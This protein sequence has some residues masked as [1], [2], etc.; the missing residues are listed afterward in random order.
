[1]GLHPDLARMIAASNEENPL[2]IKDMSPDQARALLRARYLERGYQD[3]HSVDVRQIEIAH[4][5][6]T[7]PLQ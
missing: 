7:F 6:G 4:A 3:A 1:M 2:D 5:T